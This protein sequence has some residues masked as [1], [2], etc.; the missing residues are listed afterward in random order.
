MPNTRSLEGGALMDDKVREGLEVAL[1]E[2]MRR[3]EEMERT[4]TSLREMLGVVPSASAG[5]PQKSSVAPAA[6][7]D[8]SS[9]VFEGEFYSMSATKATRALL[10]KFEQQKRP[11][12]TDEILRA[13]K[14]GGVSTS[15]SSVLYRSLWRDN[16]LHNVGKGRWGLAA[17]YPH[18]PKR[19]K[20]APVE[21]AE[22]EE[23]PEAR[24]S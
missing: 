1:A 8:P 13:I 19:S 6:D 17:W 4:I 5:T 24:A 14:K 18:A 3:R 10:A 7:A 12:K 23:E 15:S 21:E 20:N 11:L 9:L 16:A 22:A 2:A